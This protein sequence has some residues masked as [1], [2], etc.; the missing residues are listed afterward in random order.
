[1]GDFFEGMAE[2][3]PGPPHARSRAL[4]LLLK[5]ACR[6]FN[7]HQG[8]HEGTPTRLSSTSF[9]GAV[10]KARG[11]RR[12]ASRAPNKAELE[13]PAENDDAVSSSPSSP[14]SSANAF[15]ATDCTDSDTASCLRSPTD[16]HIHADD[17]ATSSPAAFTLSPESER[18]S[19]SPCPRPC[20][21]RAD[22]PRAGG[23][24][25]ARRPPHPSAAARFSGSQPIASADD[26]ADHPKPSEP[27]ACGGVQGDHPTGPRRE[28]RQ[29]FVPF[30]AP[31]QP[32]VTDDD[33]PSREYT[34]LYRPVA[35]R[36]HFL[37][38]SGDAIA[39]FLSG[40]PGAHRVRPNLRR[41]VVA[42]D[43][44]PGEDLTALLAVRVICDVRVRAKALILN[45]C[46]G[47]LFDVDPT[48]DGATIFEGLESSVPVVAIARS[49]DVVTLRFAG[50]VV[51]E[52]VLL[53]RRRRVVRPRLPRPLQCGRCG[54]F[55]HATV[56]CSRDPRC[57]QCTG[58]H[59]TN[60]CTV[61]R[62]RCLHCGGPHAATEPRCPQWQLERRVAAT[63]ASS[64]PRITR[65]QALELARSSGAAVIDSSKQRPAGQRA[66]ES[67]PL[68]S[69]RQPG[70]SYSAALTGGT[71]ADSSISGGVGEPPVT[72]DN[73]VQ[74]PGATAPVTSV[75]VLTALASALRSL[76]ELAP[77]DS[78]ARH[79]MASTPREQR[80][81]IVQWNVRSMRCRH[82][83][84]AGGAL[85]DGCDVLALQETYVRAGELNLPGFVAY[86]SATSCQQASCTASPCVDPSHPAG[87]SR[88]SV[89]VRAGLAQAEV[90]VCD[91]PCANVEC[92]A[93]TVRVGATDT[94]VASVYV[95]SGRRWDT[96]FVCRLSDR[97][98]GGGGD[99]V[100]CRDFNSHHTAWGSNHIDCSGRGLLDSVL[101]AGLLNANTGAVTFVRR[102]CAGSAIDLTL[103]S[104]RC[105]YAWRRNPDTAGSDHFPIF[106]VPRATAD[107]PTRSYSVVNW[108]R[109]RELCAAVPVSECGL[110]RHIAECARAATTRCVVPAG[111][112]VPDIKQLNLR[113]ARRRAQRKAVRTDKR[114]HWTVYNL[115]D[116]VCRRHARQRRS[117]SWSS[118]C[119]SLDDPRARSRPWRILGA[120]LRPRVPRCPALSIALAELLAATFCPP[121]AALTR[122]TGI[123]QPHHHPRRELMAPQRYF[124][125]AGT[126]EEISALCTADFTIGELRTV[127]ASRRRRSAPGSDGVTY[128]MLRN[129]DSD[130]LHHLLDAY[131]AV[132]RSGVIPREWSEA[133]VVPLLKNGKPPRDPASYRP[134][135]LTSAAGK[136]LEAM[137]LRRLEWIAAVLDILAAEQSGFRRLRAS[138]DSLA[139]VVTTLVEAKH[140]GDA[141][142]FVLLDVMSAFDQLPHATILDALCAMGVSGRLVAYVGAFLSG[143]TMRVRVGGAL[144]QPRASALDAVDEYVC[145]IGL[146]LLAAK[147]EAMLVHPRYGAHR[148]APCFSLRGESLPWRMKVR[149]L[150]LIVDHR[151][152]WQ[153]AVAALRK[154]TKLVASAARTLLARGQGCCPTLALRLYNSVASARLLYGLPLADLSPAKWEA[155]DTDHRAVVR[156]L[157]CLP[158]TS[159][160]LLFP[161]T[162][163]SIA[164]HAFASLLVYLEDA[165]LRSRR[166]TTTSSADHATPDEDLA[167]VER[168]REQQRQFNRRRRANATE[169]DRAREAKRKRDAC[170]RSAEPSQRFPG[171]TSIFRREFIESRLRHHVSRL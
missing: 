113:A 134:V 7:P 25:L 83:E 85:L 87:R 119:C 123:L 129:F 125:A 105:H 71:Q 145:G 13:S 9:K 101:R 61:D 3:R 91:L 62:R 133:V 151:L 35:R 22:L 106:L 149:Y 148:S 160:Q 95:R 159:P 48:F 143:R 171:A 57:L 50:D 66:T 46:T 136:V 102:G 152:K 124:P 114:E 37:A 120:V 31:L 88:A 150:G 1:M 144:S 54:L 163:S 82:P 43:T 162:H 38:A 41:N 8:N 28:K 81:R 26:L 58:R 18:K 14:T 137:A 169:Y 116:A 19:S 78:P 111:T 93:V 110:F 27:P 17:T 168:R 12:V 49:G 68:S 63:L 24:P 4:D 122:P 155:L 90:N 170:H 98:G 80:P 77:A 84:L 142:Y 147:T 5:E 29:R 11:A 76:L 138:A 39:A 40:V 20:R 67:R 55:G 42:V 107:L 153:P 99:L 161:A 130:Q 132:W 127:L 126:L 164:R 103:V 75:L 141:S 59:P 70:L 108:P 53:F 16:S 158:H 51:P 156:Q 97:V 131:N 118:L 10:R 104:D 34:V 165:N 140:R 52:E 73:P 89:Y 86:H 92:V 64:K 6:M 157:L 32:Q 167:R 128:Q 56:T 15:S 115:L 45:T 79:I 139:D 44:L 112:P 47:T 36:S 21:A 74:P 96:E 65:K 30:V 135:S 2:L 146:T 94:C 121:T 33:L 109:F 166:P 117:S 23:L 60:Y 72:D 154:G 69:R 100:V